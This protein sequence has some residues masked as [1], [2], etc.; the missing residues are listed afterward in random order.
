[1]K[2]RQKRNRVRYIIASASLLIALPGCLATRGW[3]Q[4]Q[5]IPLDSRLSTVE[6]RMDNAENRLSTVE[7]KADQ[8]L[9]N[10][11][12]LRLERRFVLSLQDGATFSFDSASLSLDARQQIDGFLSDLE[13]TQN[14][15][16]LVAGHTDSVGSEQYNF[17]LG[18]KRAATVARYLISHRGIDP[19]HVTTTSYGSSAPIGRN[20]T[21]EGRR[22]NRR[23]EILVYK[24]GITTAPSP[25]SHMATY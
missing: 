7:S 22:K 3:V 2:P 1:M 24:E 19:L 20:T 18:Q 11:D 13:T 10:F 21:T 4:E 12:K 8:A 23:V 9:A 25:S 5:L 14:V 17:D 15:V 6:S 16:F